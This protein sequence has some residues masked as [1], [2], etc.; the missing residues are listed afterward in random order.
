MLL[1]LAS[2][3]TVGLN[4]PFLTQALALHNGQPLLQTWGLVV[5]WHPNQP[6]DDSEY[7][8][9]YA[10]P[11]PRIDPA[12]DVFSHVSDYH[13]ID[14]TKL[15]DLNLPAVAYPLHDPMEPAFPGPLGAFPDIASNDDNNGTEL[16]KDANFEAENFDD[17]EGAPD[18]NAEDNEGAPDNNAE[19]E[20]AHEEEVHEHGATD[21]A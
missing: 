7:N 12:S 9:D 4:Y 18:N 1:G 8:T 3:D 15:A 20:G 6:I 13:P 10:P 19:K 14:N 11:T 16:D 5:E 2:L 17:E 21:T